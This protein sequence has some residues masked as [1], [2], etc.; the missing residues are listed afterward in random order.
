MIVNHRR[1]SR[2]GVDIR[3]VILVLREMRLD[4]INRQRKLTFTR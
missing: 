3:G 1:Q 2:R 4:T